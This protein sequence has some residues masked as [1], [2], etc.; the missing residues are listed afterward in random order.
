MLGGTM[1]EWKQGK[2]GEPGSRTGA[3][4]SQARRAALIPFPVI[5]SNFS[6]VAPVRI[7]GDRAGQIAS[8][9]HLS[10]KDGSGCAF[11]KGLPRNVLV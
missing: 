7:S 1:I 8:P 10:G 5:V 9:R 11:R 4:S 3:F 2:I 6:K